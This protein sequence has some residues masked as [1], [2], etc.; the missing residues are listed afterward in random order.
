MSIDNCEPSVLKRVQKLC[1]RHEFAVSYDARSVQ[2]LIVAVLAL[3]GL[4][5][6]DK[7]SLTELEKACD[8]GKADLEKPFQVSGDS[9]AR[10]CIVFQRPDLLR[11]L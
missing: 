3:L 10:L 9:Y 11:I 7:I 2:D 5:Q 8:A 6:S 4:V 1:K